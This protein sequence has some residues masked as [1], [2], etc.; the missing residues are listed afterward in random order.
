MV[1]NKMSAKF[2][3]CMFGVLVSM[4]CIACGATSRM[5]QAIVSN[6]EGVP[7][8]TIPKNSE[9]RDGIPLD[10]L[11]VSELT[12]PDESTYPDELWQFSVEPPG[13]SITLR[14][15][16]CILY[17]TPPKLAKQNSLTPLKPFHVYAVFLHAVPKGT[18]LRGY[19]AD[20]CVFP[21]KSGKTS[22]KVIPWNEA[23]KKWQYE[24]CAKPQN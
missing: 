4:S 19:K 9:T 13:N 7:C 6:F 1:K 23:E 11:I 20:F 22:V 3:H 2:W 16:K 12:S 15:E 18:S 24:I 17:G 10:G 14:P 21:E 5:G 8:F